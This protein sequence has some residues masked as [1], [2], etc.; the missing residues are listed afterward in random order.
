MISFRNIT[1]VYQAGAKPIVALSNV[2]FDIQP[3][4][5]VSIVGRSGAGKTTLLKLFLAEEKPTAGSIFFEKKDVHQIKSHLLPNFR[6]DIGVVFQDY[7]LLPSKTTYEN[8]AYVLE[9][10]G[11][12]DVDIKNDVARVLELVGLSNRAQNFPEELSGGERQ[13]A[14]IARALVHQPKVILADEPTGNLDPYCTKDIIRLLTKIN[15]MGTTV[16]LAT[17]DQ[18]I[19]NSLVRRVITLE[20][21]KVIRDEERGRFT[22]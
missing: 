13:R 1:K 2:C 18:Y 6:R 16:I 14:A 20:E 9:V 11:A 5:F 17:H 10:M 22:L 21:G 3:Q 19:I 4:E 12:S 15:E 7:K 8:I